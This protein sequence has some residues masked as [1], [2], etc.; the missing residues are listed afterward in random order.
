MSPLDCEQIDFGEDEENARFCPHALERMAER[1]TTEQ[2]VRD[3]IRR[4]EQFPV[5]H[6]RTGFRRNFIF[7]GVWRGRQY[8]NK[9]VE[10]IAVKEDGAWLVI[11]IIVRYF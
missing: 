6:G 1:G 7:G 8:A 4:G 3:T 9:Q 5:Q 11:T 10:A 2:Q